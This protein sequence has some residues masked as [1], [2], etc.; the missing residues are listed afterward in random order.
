MNESRFLSGIYRLREIPAKSLSQFEITSPTPEGILA[1]GETLFLPLEIRAKGLGLLQETLAVEIQGS[2]KTL[3]VPVIGQGVG[4]VVIADPVSVD[5]G[6]IQA[7]V[8]QIKTAN[9]AA[10]DQESKL[11]CESNKTLKC[12]KSLR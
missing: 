2:K 5:F 3:A 6:V 4:P 1:P 9:L 12:F 10:F 11:K 8:R 7:K